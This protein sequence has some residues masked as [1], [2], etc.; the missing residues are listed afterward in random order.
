MD[1]LDKHKNESGDFKD[2]VY[3][4]HR[5]GKKYDKNGCVIPQEKDALNMMKKFKVLE[6]INMQEI[7]LQVMK[8]IKL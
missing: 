1:M 2:K 3:A 6:Y 5:D 7:K 8:Y 4:N